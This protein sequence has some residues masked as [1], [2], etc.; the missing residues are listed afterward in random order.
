MPKTN[1]PNF[2]SIASRTLTT[3]G[4]CGFPMPELER[5]DEAAHQRWAATLA[6]ILR[7]EMGYDGAAD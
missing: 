6:S 4:E 7:A 5:G 2:E 1:E 3:L